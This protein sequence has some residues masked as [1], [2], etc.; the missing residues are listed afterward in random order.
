MA[1]MLDV[2][3]AA[4]LVGMLMLTILNVN[5]NMTMETYKSAAEFHTQTEVI[6]LARIMEYDIYKMGYNVSKPCIVT[7]DTSHLKFRA[8]LQDI[9]GARDSVEYLLG[10]AVTTSE[11]PRDKHLL[12][13]ENVS[14]VSIS[15]SVTRFRLTYYDARDSV[16]PTPVTGFMLDSIRAVKVYLSLE[17]PAQFDSSYAGAFYEKIIYPRNLQ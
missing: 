17:S 4:L 8:N 14:H 9:A 12:R 15:Y 6:Q 11:N 16:M 1:V 13:V 7:A 3:G 5:I 10:T 2:I